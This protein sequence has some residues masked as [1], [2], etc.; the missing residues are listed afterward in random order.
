MAVRMYKVF[1]R[2]LEIAREKFSLVNPLCYISEVFLGTYTD[3]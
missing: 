1:L 3:L 2:F